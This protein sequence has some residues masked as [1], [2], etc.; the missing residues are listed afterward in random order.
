MKIEH[1]DID[2]KKEMKELIEKLNENMSMNE[3]FDLIFRSVEIPFILGKI[4]PRCDG[5]IATTFVD[6]T[7]SE[8]MDEAL[9]IGLLF[10]SH[11]NKCVGNLEDD[12]KEEE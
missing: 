2:F 10:M 7:A 6:V 12:I 3:I 4:C 8:L 9:Y 1:V 5:M 11:L